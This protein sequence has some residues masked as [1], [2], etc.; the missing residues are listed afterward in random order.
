MCQLHWLDLKGNPKLS[1][2]NSGDVCD[3]HLLASW[4]AD[5]NIVLQSGYELKC[6]S[7]R[8]NFTHCGNMTEAMQI[9]EACVS[10]I[11]VKAKVL[12]A[13]KTWLLVVIVLGAI[14][15]TVKSVVILIHQC[16]KRKNRKQI[17]VRGKPLTV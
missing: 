2:G 7:N 11:A 5:R 13:R 16:N 9:H 4:I 15:V 17:L 12:Q 8:H 10:A 14:L 3:C 6:A 1:D